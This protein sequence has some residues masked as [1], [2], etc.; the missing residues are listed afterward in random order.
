V[1]YLAILIGLSLYP[2][3]FGPAR[4]ALVWQPIVTNR[5]IADVAGNVWAY[6]LLGA[7]A[8]LWRGGGAR[9]ASVAL[10]LGFST[11]L[12]VEYTQHWIP[13][14][15]SSSLDVL[16]DAVGVAFGVALA[17]SARKWRWRWIEPAARLHKEAALLLG[18]WGIWQAFPFLP[19]FRTWKLEEAY[20]RLL[21]FEWSWGEVSQVFAAFLILGFALN[22]SLWRMVA[23]ALLPVQTLL[24]G[25]TL[26]PASILAA[27]A[28]WAVAEAAVRRDFA[29][30]PWTIRCAVLLWLASEELRPFRF[31]AQ[32]QPLGWIPLESLYLSGPESYYLPALG[33]LFLYTAA[34]WVMRRTGWSLRRAMLVEGAVLL[35]GEWV[36]RWIPPRTPELTDLVLLLAGG[37]M[38]HWASRATFSGSSRGNA[39]SG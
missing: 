9:G 31:S 26:A 2:W 35:A 19:V 36:Q 16:A 21:Q 23:F 6:A 28:A 24:T 11:S 22:G 7:L 4:P 10:L 29:I 14:R 30:P 1:G 17:W 34:L 33:K 20:Q 15:F 38:L 25:H 8:F 13:G 5:Q 3:R 32:P 18:L 39:A 27:A 37:L 12:A